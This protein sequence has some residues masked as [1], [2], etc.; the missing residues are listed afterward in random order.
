[1]VLFSQG[2]QHGEPTIHSDGVI[3]LKDYITHDE[4]FS[5]S[6]DAKVAGLLSSFARWHAGYRHGFEQHMANLNIQT[7]VFNRSARNN[8]ALDRWFELGDEAFRKRESRG[9]P[10][11]DVDDLDD[12]NYRLY[13]HVYLRKQ[14]GKEL[15]QDMFR[16][17]Y[18]QVNITDSLINRK[19]T[20]KI[21]T[22]IINAVSY[23]YEEAPH[24]LD[25]FLKSLNHPYEASKGWP[26][27]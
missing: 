26:C 6:A 22:P 7:W 3:H 16:Y 20:T 25:S 1:M 19:E 21:T 2:S 23:L 5:M 9:R 27:N 14:F 11:F 24:R 8:G 4:H 18:S 15:P 10:D 13:L 17:A 12:D